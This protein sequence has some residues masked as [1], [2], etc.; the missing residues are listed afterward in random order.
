MDDYPRGYRPTYQAQVA[1]QWLMEQQIL[2]DERGLEL[3]ATR[4]GVLL[5][6]PHTG[7]IVD[8]IDAPDPVSPAAFHY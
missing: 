6:E 7:E 2:A 3:E 8:E 5:R 4:Y 1:E